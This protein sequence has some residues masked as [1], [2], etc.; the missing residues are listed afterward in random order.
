MQVVFNSL[1]FPAKQL[2]E[3]YLLQVFMDNH[4]VNW[5]VLT[6][7]TGAQSEKELDPLLL[8]PLEKSVKYSNQCFVF[9]S[10]SPG[11][12]IAVKIKQIE[13]T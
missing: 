10:G 4:K 7:I 3:G 1:Q 9:F 2:K 6:I 5:N 11:H 12:S 13:V 8:I